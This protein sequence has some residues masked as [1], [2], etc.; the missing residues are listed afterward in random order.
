MFCLS[1]IYFVQLV[2]QGMKLSYPQENKEG[3]ELLKTAI[4]KAGYTDK[5]YFFLKFLSILL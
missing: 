2:S 5:V 1:S 4:A 3:L